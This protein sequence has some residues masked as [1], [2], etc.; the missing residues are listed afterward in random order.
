MGWEPTNSNDKRY[1]MLSE[2]N[3]WEHY[4]IVM[5]KKKENLKNGRRKKGTGK[6]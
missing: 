3:F 1:K 4:F 6:E 5:L 2:G